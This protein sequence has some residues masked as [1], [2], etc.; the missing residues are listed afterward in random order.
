MVEAAPVIALRALGLARPIIV[1][2]DHDE[3]G[4]THHLNDLG[5]TPYLL[6]TSAENMLRIEILGELEC[7]GVKAIWVAQLNMGE[8]KGSVGETTP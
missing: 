1:I 8:N 6:I 4:A 3:W 2:T 7:D 5:D